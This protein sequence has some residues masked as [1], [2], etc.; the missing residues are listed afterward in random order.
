MLTS[1]NVEIEDARQLIE[2]LAKRIDPGIRVEA[3]GSA[4]DGYFDLA[5]RKGRKVRRIRV[6]EEEVLNA[7]RD[8]RD[9]M[10]LLWEAWQA[11]HEYASDLG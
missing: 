4:R 2:G 7:R 11:K 9:V 8:P 10:D 1:W 5:L 6:T 3:D